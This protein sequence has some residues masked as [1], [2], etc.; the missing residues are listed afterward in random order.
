MKVFSIDSKQKRNAFW[1]RRGALL[2]LNGDYIRLR[3]GFLWITVK[4]RPEWCFRITLQ[5]AKQFLRDGR[6][7]LL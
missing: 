5:G 2:T 3:Y 6:R 4:A 1:L 7:V